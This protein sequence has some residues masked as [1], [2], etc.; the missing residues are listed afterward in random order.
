MGEVATATVGRQG[1]T[2]APKMALLAFCMLIFS[3]D[4]NIVYVALPEIGKEVGFSAQSLQW[5]VSA[6]SVGLGGLLLLGGRAADRLGARRLLVVAL[7]LYSVAS[8]VGGVATGAGTLVGARVVQGIGGALLF[9]AT[10]SLIATNF[11]EGPQR[12]KAFAWWGTAGASGAIVGAMLGGLLTNYLGWRWVF[13]ANIPLCVV[14]VVGALTLL[15]ADTRREQGAGRFDIPGALVATA[16]ITLLVFGLIGGPTYHWDSPVVIGTLVA[17]AVLLALFF[18]IERLSRD[19]LAPARLF[20]VRSLVI[21]MAI[22]F[23][24]QGAINTLHYLFFIDIQDVLGY[25][26]LQAGLAFLPMSA[27]AMIGSNRLLPFLL[28]KLGARAVLFIGMLGVGASMIVLAATMTTDR[29]YWVLLPAVLL[30][31]LFAGMLYPAMFMT[32]GSGVAPTEQGVASG[33]AQ[34]AAQLGGA[35]GMAALIAVANIGLDLS[36][37]AVNP[38]SEV[39]DGLKTSSL[40]GGIAVVVAAFLAFLIPGAAPAAGEAAESQ[41]VPPTET[42]GEAAAV[43]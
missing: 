35:M 21:A 32:A 12:N 17:G 43:Q 24:F 33:L 22:I 11:T 19:P 41:D 6:Y 39:L 4:Y 18:V 27:F 28:G 9:P 16:A 2:A 3:I 26:P 38:V 1:G 15:A 34:T 36:D 8:L 23:V 13:F 40:F 10:L 7:L 37:G 5:V 14:A 31:G 30:W 29:S 20:T 25:N 42:L